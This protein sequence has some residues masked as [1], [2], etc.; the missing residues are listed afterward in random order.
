MAA[1]LSLGQTRW[2]SLWARLPSLPWAHCGGWTCA[3]ALLL[4]AAA[5]LNWAEASRAADPRARRSAPAG[6]PAKSPPPQANLRVREGTEIVD[7]LGYFQISGDR[8]VFFTADGQRRFAGLENLQLERIA[9]VVADTPQPLQWGVTG[10]IT[11]YR[12]ANFLLVR[13]AILKS[14]LLSPAGNF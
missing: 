4:A 8:V 11:E 10:T 13:R 1:G 3:A 5:A 6:T 9:R 12:G 2:A 7:Q 14:G